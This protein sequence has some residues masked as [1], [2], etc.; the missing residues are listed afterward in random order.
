MKDISN[1]NFIEELN[2]ALDSYNV[3]FKAQEE[4]DELGKF[5]DENGKEIILKCDYESYKLE[6]NNIKYYDDYLLVGE[7]FIVCILY[8]SNNTLRNINQ[9]TFTNNIKGNI[10]TSKDS[11]PI[12]TT[13]IDKIFRI[14][15]LDFDYIDEINIDELVEDNIVILE[16]EN[17]EKLII[18][19]KPN[20]DLINELIYSILVSLAKEK[21]IILSYR[22]N[23]YLD[24]SKNS[25][26][27]I[28]NDFDMSINKINNVECMQYFMSA[29]EIQ[30]PHFKYLE[31]YHI[32]EYYFLKT[33]INKTKELIKNAVTIQLVNGPIDDNDY[34]KLFEQ[35]FNHYLKKG[36]ENKEEVQLRHVICDDL[37]VEVIFPILSSLLSSE[38]D[39]KFLGEPLF[40][41][42][43]VRIQNLNSF[44]DKKNNKFKD[45]L[46]PEL[47]NDFCEE[48]CNRIYK[49][50]N[51]CVH[52]KK[53][54]N[55]NI[56]T[57]IKSNLKS[58]EKDIILIRR[59][60]LGI[61]YQLE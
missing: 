60:A 8:D 23:D 19:E 56:L 21:G 34:Y 4:T 59:I 51:Y 26:Q 36:D 13:N 40:N 1:F 52:T 54:E 17:I 2:Q 6:M 35:M 37:G 12:L 47:K 32:I 44:Y 46:S 45:G 33:S 31:Y 10:K 39:F 18:D 48:L 41:D 58:L 53:S 29:E 3:N 14:I 57:P 27:P 42:N 49:I 11:I 16:I 20:L 38:F 15:T 61:I 22:K 24:L 30:A 28:Q 25:S 7:D 43:T 5:V 50:R 55:Y 9:I